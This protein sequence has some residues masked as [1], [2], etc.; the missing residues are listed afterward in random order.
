MHACQ[1][2]PATSNAN[3]DGE[4]TVGLMVAKIYLF[5]IVHI[6][7]SLNTHYRKL[8]P[9]KQSYAEPDDFRP[10]P[11]FKIVSYLPHMKFVCNFYQK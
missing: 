2:G 7:M 10:Y 5:S 3:S 8:S 6:N 4:D 1:A 11:E 9:N